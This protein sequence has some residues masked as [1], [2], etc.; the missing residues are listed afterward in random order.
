MA[1]AAESEGASELWRWAEPL[2]H[3][4]L[5]ETYELAFED[6]EVAR[7][8]AAAHAQ[9]WR[10]LESGAPANAAIDLLDQA[11]ARHPN[12][13]EVFHNANA[14]VVRELADTLRRRYRVSVRSRE[15]YE[16]TLMA[17]GMGFAA[18]AR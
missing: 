8:V 7:E 13:P 2:I 5:R 16:R 3:D 12:G 17:I 18:S 6:E 10:A 4:I 1:F 15:T 9:L 14:A 11:L